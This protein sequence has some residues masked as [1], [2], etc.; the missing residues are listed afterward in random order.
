MAYY[1]ENCNA[2]VIKLHAAEGKFEG[3]KCFEKR[4]ITFKYYLLK[5]S[6]S[7][8]K[9]TVNGEEVG[10]VKAQK[11]SLVFPLNTEQKAPDGGVISVSLKI[12]VNKE[13]EIKFYL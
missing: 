10:F 4:E 13:Y 1:C 8:K 2:Y 5:D 6:D 7:V 3:E 11:Q 12:D 9:V